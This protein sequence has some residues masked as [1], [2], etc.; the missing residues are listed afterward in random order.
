MLLLGLAVFCSPL[1]IVPLS[2][3]T[4][5]VFGKAD[6]T[7][8]RPYSLVS[9][10][11]LAGRTKTQTRYVF[12]SHGV[13]WGLPQAV[14]RLLVLGLTVH[15]FIPF[16]PLPF[17]GSGWEWQPLGPGHTQPRPQLRVPYSLP[18]P[19]HTVTLQNSLQLTQ[20]IICFF[21]FSFCQDRN[22][23]CCLYQ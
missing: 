13:P 12:F 4:F 5:P 16:S 6:C 20:C 18:A 22:T 1:H 2:L 23:V 3:S 7:H 19:L 15:C 11:P 8:G 10:G 9:G 14:L 17:L 21:F